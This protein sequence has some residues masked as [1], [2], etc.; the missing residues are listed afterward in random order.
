LFFLAIEFTDGKPGSH[1]AF[2]ELL[3]SQG[4]APHSD[5][6]PRVLP[7]AE[8]EEK[9]YVVFDAAHIVTSVGLLDSVDGTKYKTMIRAFDRNMRAT[10]NETKTLSIIKLQ[11]KNKKNRI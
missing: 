3:K 6:I 11:K 5:S 10:A 2:G 4:V 8:D 7:F 1:Y 9:K